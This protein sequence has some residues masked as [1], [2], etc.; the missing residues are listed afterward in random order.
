MIIKDDDG[1]IIMIRK[2]KDKKK[3]TRKQILEEIR[4]EEQLKDYYKN[5][6]EKDEK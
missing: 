1:R 2:K 6:V 5:G 3:K 4:C